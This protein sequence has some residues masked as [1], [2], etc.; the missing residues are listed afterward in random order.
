MPRSFE[1]KVCHLGLVWLL[2]NCL[3]QIDG[4]ICLTQLCPWCQETLRLSPFSLWASVLHLY[5]SRTAPSTPV[6]LTE[7]INVPNPLTTAVRMEEEGVDTNTD[8]DKLYTDV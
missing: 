3:V 1:R 4:C 8:C 2:S 6:N 5:Q 7:M